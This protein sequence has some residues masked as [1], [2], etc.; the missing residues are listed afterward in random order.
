MSGAASSERQSS[1]QRFCRTVF[2]YEGVLLLVTG[3]LMLV[4]PQV[5]L[6]AQGFASSAVD[7]PVVRG[8]LQQFGALRPWGALRGRG[9]GRDVKTQRPVELQHLSSGAGRKASQATGV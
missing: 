9:R 3:T 1:L 2:F 6:R 4:A 7:D 5:A 8:N